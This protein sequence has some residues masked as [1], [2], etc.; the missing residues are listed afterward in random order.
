[1]SGSGRQRWAVRIVGSNV[2][3]LFKLS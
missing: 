3:L 2:Q 1:V